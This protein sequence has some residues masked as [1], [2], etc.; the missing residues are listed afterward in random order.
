M[1][2]QSLEQMEPIFNSNKNIEKEPDECIGQEGDTLVPNG[3]TTSFILPPSQCPNFLDS[4]GN[5]RISGGISHPTLRYGK[6]SH[7]H[8]ESTWHRVDAH[9]AE[10]K[11]GCSCAGDDLHLFRLKRLQK[12]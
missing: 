6:Q 8:N 5:A 12:Y 9:Q 11:L 2:M 4:F 7:R 10:L 1:V 3:G